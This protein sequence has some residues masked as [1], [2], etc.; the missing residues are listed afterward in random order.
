MYFQIV[1]VGLAV[2]V[3]PPGVPL[4]HAVPAPGVAELPGAGVFVGARLVGAGVPRGGGVLGGGFVPCAVGWL[5]GCGVAW[6]TFVQV[7]LPVLG[8]KVHC[9]GGG[10]HPCAN[11]CPAMLKHRTSAQMLAS[12]RR[13]Y[14]YG[15]V[16][17]FCLS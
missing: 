2:G 8:L 9:G 5:V 13:L 7:I 3:P 14:I 16:R 17:I 4:G 15:R 10:V 11:V 6:Q 12:D 1:G